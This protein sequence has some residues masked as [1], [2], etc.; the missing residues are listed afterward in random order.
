[1][2]ALKQ[3]APLF[4]AFDRPKY[5]KL[6]P[7][8]KKEMLSIPE[9][10][11]SHLRSGGFSV[12]ILGRTCHSVGVDEAH[13]MCV[14]KECKEYITRPSGENMN[15]T[16]LFLPV[17]AKAIKNLEKQLFADSKAKTAQ[18]QSLGLLRKDPETKKHEVNVRA[19]VEKIHTCS[20]VLPTFQAQGSCN[21][22]RH[23]FKSQTIRS[24]QAHDLCNF[25]GIGL[26]TLQQYINFYIQNHQSTENH[27]LLSLRD[28]HARRKGPTPKKRE[29]SN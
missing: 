17:R 2:A 13:E 28:A 14:N 20:E 23:L 29:K 12:S 6:I 24:E 3:M 5:S 27:C 19:Q 25:R 22:L 8:H 15:R 26:N 16:A 21:E 11:K 1:M 18:S 7:L 4:T 9:K 10:I